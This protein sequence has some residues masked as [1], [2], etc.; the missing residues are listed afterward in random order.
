MKETLLSRSLSKKVKEQDEHHNANNDEF[1]HESV[2]ETEVD[3]QNR[4]KV[5]N[6]NN[7]KDKNKKK[8]NKNNNKKHKAM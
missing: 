4:S 6:K 3:C 8:G 7:V 1:T 2:V 5:P